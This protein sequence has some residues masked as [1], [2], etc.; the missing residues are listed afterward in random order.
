MMISDVLL[1]QV[2]EGA[3]LASGQTLRIDRIPA[4]FDDGFEPEKSRIP[5]TLTRISEKCTNKGYELKKDA[6]GSTCQVKQ[7]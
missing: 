5:A 6:T 7:E 3:L 2:I 1:E 4:L